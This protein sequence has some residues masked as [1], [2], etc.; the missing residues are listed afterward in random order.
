MDK[1]ASD[2]HITYTAGE[3]RLEFRIVAGGSFSLSLVNARSWQQT[4][5]SF[6]LYVEAYEADNDTH[7]GPS[8]SPL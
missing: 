1:T 3:R 8:S 2:R 4:F 7:L 6:E 5:T